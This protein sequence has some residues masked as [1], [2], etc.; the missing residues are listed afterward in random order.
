MNE[1]KQM[2]ALVQCYIHHKKG[3]EVEINLNQFN[4]PI[5]VLLL[6]QAYEVAIKNLHK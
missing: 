5:N 3:I 2:I 6:R 1:I 4:N